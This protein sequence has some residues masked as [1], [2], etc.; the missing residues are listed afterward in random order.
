MSE[1]T[2]QETPQTE[3]PHT[4]L[5]LDDVTPTDSAMLVNKHEELVHIHGGVATRIVFKKCE[6]MTLDE[7]LAKDVPSMVAER[8][9]L[10]TIRDEISSR[11]YLV[12]DANQVIRYSGCDVNDLP[13]TELSEH[14]RVRKGMQLVPNLTYPLVAWCETDDSS[15][16]TITVRLDNWHFRFKNDR[17]KLDVELYMPPLWFSVTLTSALMMRGMRV[18]V[19]REVMTNVYDTPLYHLPLPNIYQSGRI[20]EGASRLGISLPQDRI[21]ENA[22]INAAITRFWNSGWNLDLTSGVRYDTIL[23]GGRSP[24]SYP[25]YDAVVAEHPD[26]TK[27]FKRAMSLAEDDWQIER[28]VRL[29]TVLSV[30]N[31]WVNCAFRKIVSDHGEEPITTAAWLNNKKD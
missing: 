17:L 3:A 16:K 7:F 30:P 6:V 18:A 15:L 31:G 13:L 23:G 5:P 29:L 10:L 4:E 12:Y 21:T 25:V 27:P 9:Q 28:L 11:N 1:E 26:C 2:Q 8:N 22:V 19:A 14:L 20:C 24:G